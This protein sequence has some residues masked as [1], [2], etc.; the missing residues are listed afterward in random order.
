MTYRQRRISPDGRPIHIRQQMHV[1]PA[2]LAR[3][4]RAYRLIDAIAENGKRAVRK[5]VRG[6]ER[7]VTACRTPS[8][9]WLVDFFEHDG[10]PSTTEKGS[11]GWIAVTGLHSSR[12]TSGHDTT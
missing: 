4:R 2:W 6:P 11:T 9:S 1:I 5:L 8:S 3:R 10:P 7:A 12:K